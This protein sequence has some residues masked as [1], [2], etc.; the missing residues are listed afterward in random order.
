MYV[1]LT[2]EDEFKLLSDELGRIFT[3]NIL[4]EWAKNDQFKQ[5][6]EKG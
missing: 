2:I 6:K 5:R 1:E 4:D 3:S